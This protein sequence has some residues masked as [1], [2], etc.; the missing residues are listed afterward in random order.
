MSTHILERKCQMATTKLSGL[1]ISEI[2]EEET[3]LIFLQCIDDPAFLT[4]VGEDVG[5][6]QS[7]VL[8]IIYC[9]IDAIKRKA[10]DFLKISINLNLQ[11]L[12]SKNDI[13]YF[14]C[15]NRIYLLYSCTY[16]YRSLAFMQTTIFFPL[17]RPRSLDYRP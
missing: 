2:R 12:N 1:K 9:V 11:K 8:L 15:C 17:H 7:A 5:V 13:Y 3:M 10:H 16:P 4:G 6:N 14:S